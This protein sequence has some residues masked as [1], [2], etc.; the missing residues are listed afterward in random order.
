MNNP[1]MKSVLDTTMANLAEEVM[2]IHEEFGEDMGEL[3]VHIN[4]D[5]ETEPCEDCDCELADEGLGF[6]LV[7]FDVDE[8]CDGF[9]EPGP[10]VIDSLDKFSEALGDIVNQFSDMVL[11]AKDDMMAGLE[12]L[13][14]A[15]E[16]QGLDEALLTSVVMVKMNQAVTRLEE[17]FN[18]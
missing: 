3:R 1:E 11:D 10:I 2:A 14:E 12:Q 15:T 13:V 4:Y 8:P 16:D 9:A 5:T 18:V 6:V 7:G 17:A